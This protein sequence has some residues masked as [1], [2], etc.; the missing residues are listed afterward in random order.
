[1][2]LRIAFPVSPLFLK[3]SALPPGCTLC[4]AEFS[5]RLRPR[6]FRSVFSVAYRLF[7]SL[8]SLVPH[9]CLCFQ[10]VTHSFAKTPGVWGVNVAEGAMVDARLAGAGACGIVGRAAAEHCVV[11]CRSRGSVLRR[12]RRGWHRHA[13][14]DLALRTAD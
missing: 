10:S 8:C 13:A 1:M 12:K 2:V 5:P 7:F 14:S 4:V 11:N 3:R 6:L 9:P